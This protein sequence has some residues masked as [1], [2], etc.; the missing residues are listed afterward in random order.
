M[1]TRVLIL[2]TSV[3]FGIKATAEAILEK[4]QK[5]DVFE[6]RIEDVEKVE[7]GISSSIIKKA[8][9]RILDNFSGLWGYLYQSG[10]VM[11][12]ALPLRKFIASFKSKHVLRILREFQPAMVISTQ[13]V[14]SAMVAYLK[15]KGL[16]RGKLVAVFSDYHLHEFWLYKE[17]DLYI[18]NIEEQVQG[19]INLGIPKEKTALTGTIILDK[20]FEPISRE[21]AC[22]QLGL[23]TSMPT[24]IL[25][26]AGRARESNKEIFLQLL[27]SEKSFQIVVIC[28]N[29]QQLREELKK[30]S[31]PS[32]HP[33]KILGY[34]NNMDVLMSAASVLVYKTGGPSMAEAVVKKLPMVLTDVRPGHELVNLEYLLHNNIAYYARIKREVAFL[35]EQ[36]LEGKLKINFESAFAKI[37]KPPKSVSVVDSLR[38]IL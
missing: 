19:L 12:I 34:V 7:A 9:L 25:G 36:I 13:T 11:A 17:V 2:H 32:R 10:L 29:N 16:Y 38:T 1:K 3:G 30:I 15:S 20:F 33:A 27:R 28:G 21:L 4:L 26:G 14:P 8:Y 23:L 18:C 6:V 31:T 35:A 24:I 22:E 5:S 37:I